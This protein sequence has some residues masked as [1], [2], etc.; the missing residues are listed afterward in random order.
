[1]SI[2]ERD[3]AILDFMVKQDK[4]TLTKEDWSKIDKIQ[5]DNENWSKFKE[6]MKAV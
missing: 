1:M 6:T 3:I 2:N 5:K 4:G